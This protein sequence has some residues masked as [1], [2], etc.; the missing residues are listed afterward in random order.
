LVVT[1][2]AQTLDVREL[3]GRSLLDSL[4]AYLR[5]RQALLLLDNFE[6]VL[7]AAPDIAALLATAPG[8]KI[9]VTSRAVLHLRGEKE[10][11]VPPLALPNPT[12]LPP[13]ARLSQ[14]AAVALFIERALDVQP[15]FAVTNE[16]APAVA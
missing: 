7:Q 10:I 1:T 15:D 8:V 6:Q 4:Q 3:S 11:T 5:D 9:L 12:Q 13:L 2:I 16:N 14:Y